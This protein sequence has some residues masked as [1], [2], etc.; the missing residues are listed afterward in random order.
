MCGVHSVTNESIHAKPLIVKKRVLSSSSCQ[1]AQWQ[2][3]NEMTSQLAGGWIQ[4]R[5]R[6]RRCWD[7]P[8]SLW[9]LLVTAGHC[10][11]RPPFSVFVRA[12]L[13][14]P[15][16][17]LHSKSA[18]LT[19]WW[20]VLMDNIQRGN[21]LTWCVTHSNLLFQLQVFAKIMKDALSVWKVCFV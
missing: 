10:S 1:P 14:T 6:L 4:R 13:I 17:Q 20:T 5:N 9:S 19:Y 2:V 11:P 21:V 7:L 16:G 12:P 18:D 15:A 3:N 8:W